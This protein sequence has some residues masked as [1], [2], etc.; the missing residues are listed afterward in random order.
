MRKKELALCVRSVRLLDC[1][2]AYYFP[3]SFNVCGLRDGS[4]GAI[5]SNGRV[6]ESITEPAGNLVIHVRSGDV[7]RYGRAHSSYGQVRYNMK[8]FQHFVCSKSTS[9]ANRA[10]RTF[11]HS[12]FIEW[13]RNRHVD[14]ILATQLTCYVLHTGRFRFWYIQSNHWCD[15]KTGSC[16]H[17][18]GRCSIPSSIQRLPFRNIPGTYQV[19]YVN[20]SSGT[21]A[22]QPPFREC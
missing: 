19:S 6:A 2:A 11:N 20:V 21:V 10:V 1:E 12:R 17:F 4:A 8:S 15:W 13:R 7:F 5:A 18:C 16:K 22:R 9:V 3:K 14:A